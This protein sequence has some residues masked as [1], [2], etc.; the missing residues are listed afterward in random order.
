[1]LAKVTN[2][3]LLAID[4]NS[5][6]ML[7]LVNL[8][9]AFDTVNHNILLEHSETCVGISGFALSCF[10]SYL[11]E[12][13]HHVIHGNATSEFC[14]VTCVVPHESVLGPLLFS[15]YMLLL[16]DIIHIYNISFHY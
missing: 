9:A 6:S 11:S 2:E 14:N 5:S 4:P 13:M 7:S 16:S 1:M 8:R 10:S 12:R 3:L 15:I